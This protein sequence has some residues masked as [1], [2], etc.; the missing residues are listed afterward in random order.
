MCKGSCARNPLPTLLTK[1]SHLR[2]KPPAARSGP[3]PPLPDKTHEEWEWIPA[4]T[5]P[6]VPPRN[7]MGVWVGFGQLQVTPGP[8][9]GC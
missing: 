6:P 3:W 4:C 5:A 8:L 2:L 7:R 1:N 9:S